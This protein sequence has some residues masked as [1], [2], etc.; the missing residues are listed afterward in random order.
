[1]EERGGKSS[2]SGKSPHLASHKLRARPITRRGYLK[3]KEARMAP[4]DGSPRVKA[5]QNR[6]EK[7]NR[8]K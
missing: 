7:K 1:M 6:R 2:S 3:S 8:L 5:A 4:R